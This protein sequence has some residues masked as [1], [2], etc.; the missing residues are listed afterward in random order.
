M[1]KW[2]LAMAAAGMPLATV[3][4]CDFDG[5]NGSFFLDRVGRHHDD[6]FFDD[7]VV[8]IEEEEFFFDDCCF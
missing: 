7:E 1:K 3:A 4:S 5:T 8:V 6:F 2:L